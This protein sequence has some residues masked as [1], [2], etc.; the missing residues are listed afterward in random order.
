MMLDYHFLMTYLGNV[1]S[2][3]FRNLVYI[4][5]TFLGFMYLTTV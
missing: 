3:L 5:L 1:T 4:S 2:F